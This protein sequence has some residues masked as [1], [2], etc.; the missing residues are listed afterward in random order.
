MT[1]VRH[2]GSKTRDDKPSKGI[3]VK[4]STSKIDPSSRI[5]KLSSLIHSCN[6]SS[7]STYYGSDTIPGTEGMVGKRQI[8]VC[9]QELSL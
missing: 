3:R 4:A 9:S 2:P 1:M 8:G 7:L 6:N 5:L